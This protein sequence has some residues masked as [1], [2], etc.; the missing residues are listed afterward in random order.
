[1]WRSEWIVALPCAGSPKSSPHLMGGTFEATFG[2]NARP[3]IITGSS[4]GLTGGIAAISVNRP[5][6]PGRDTDEGKA[7]WSSD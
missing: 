1:M 2:K 6:A 4:P 7:R 3:T 5:F